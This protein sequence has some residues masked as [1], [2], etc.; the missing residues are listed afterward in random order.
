MI[1]GLSAQ[2]RRRH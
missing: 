2:Y 1:K